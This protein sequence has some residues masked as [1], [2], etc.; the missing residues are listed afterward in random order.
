MAIEKEMTGRDR[1]AHLP[2]TN[3][4]AQQAIIMELSRQ[5]THS[6]EGNNH[7]EEQAVMTWLRRLYSR[8]SAG[9][10]PVTEQA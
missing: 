1:A 8:D 2:D 3:H 5:E 7:G 10:K 4:A 6:P 9:T